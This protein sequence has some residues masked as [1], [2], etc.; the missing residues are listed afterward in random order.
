MRIS[1]LELVRFGHF[2]DLALRFGEPMESGDFHIVYGPN[3]SGKSTIVEAY[4]A[5]L[6]GIPERT[7]YAFRHERTSLEVRAELSAKGRKVRARRLARRKGDLYGD[8]EAPVPEAHVAALLG[9]V[10]REAYRQ[11]YCLDDGTIE[12]GG[13]EIL[14]SKGDLGRLLFSAAAGLDG[15]SDLLGAARELDEAFHQK[16]ARKPRRLNALKSEIEALGRAKAEADVTIAQHRD[17]RRRLKDADEALAEADAAHRDLLA[18]E[19]RLDALAEALPLLSEAVTARTALGALS[20]YPEVPCAWREEIRSLARR[21]AGAK[22]EL[23]AHAARIER[24]RRV[25]STVGGPCSGEG[26]DVEEALGVLGLPVSSGWAA[27]APGEAEAETLRLALET[28]ERAEAAAAAAEA[29]VRSAQGAVTQAEEARTRAESGFTAPDGLDTI[30]EEQSADRLAEDLA[31]ATAEETAAARV[32][33]QALD[34]LALPGREATDLPDA[35]LTEA[36]AR[37]LAEAIG[38]ARQE[39]SEARDRIAE[40]S[41][42]IAGLEAE[43]SSYRD[44]LGPDADGAVDEARAE[45]DR[46]WQDYRATPREELAVRV[47]AAFRETDRLA[48]AR[49]AE[50]ST[51]ASARQAAARL[52]RVS[53]ERADFAEAL[54]ETEARLAVLEKTAAHHRAA[55][56]LP[57]GATAEDLVAWVQERDH[58]RVALHDASEARRERTRLE[59][60]AE[61]VRNALAEKLGEDIRELSLGSAISAARS[62]LS[63]RK[64]QVGARQAATA[65]LAK[66][67]DELERRSG[68][69]QSLERDV[70]AAERAW[71]SQA[72]AFAAPRDPGVDRQALVSAVRLLS[73]TRA[74][75]DTRRESLD[76]EI[77]EAEGAQS[78]AEEA[79]AAVEFAADAMRG[80]F[81][82]DIDVSDLGALEGAIEASAR[83]RELRAAVA[84]LEQR[85][86]QRLGV[87]DWTAVERELAGVTLADVAVL[88]GELAPRLDAAAA[89]RDRAIGARSLAGAALAEAGS[90]ADAARLEEDRQTALAELKHETERA[91]VRRIGLRLADAAMARYRDRHRSAMLEDTGEAFAMLTEGRYPTIATQP[92]GRGERLLAE[93]ASDGR[94]VA[95]D[96]MSKGTRFQLYLALRFAGYRQMAASGTVLPFVCDDVFE[97]F[98][99]ARTAA[100]C[101][102]MR[103]ISGI[104]QAIYF[105]HHT[106]VVEIAQEVTH[107]AVAVHRID[108]PAAEMPRI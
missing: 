13:E 94:S 41:R 51:I 68:I 99:E 70:E 83:A 53:A 43:R 82:D 93:R 87:A 90:D 89:Q 6:Y 25:R 107:G 47:E 58:A 12:Q 20:R 106:H 3:E 34:R 100:A 31:R 32:M 91:L 65:A 24:L 19:A 26:G 63:E 108:A 27:M 88:R 45:R 11:L 69:Q 78:G 98:D 2:T 22:A 14:A 103:E 33:R 77:E 59:S 23:E 57:A 64:A 74:Q 80:A 15:L 35:P 28:L 21:R 29:E 67:K 96:A 92:A 37:E 86:V 81:P 55:T 1:R 76:R 40:R 46:L 52:A 62:A 97:T 7:P 49:L 17:L 8:G 44:A 16:R 60:R 4:L 5:L 18:Q 72:A 71:A 73:A 104:G 85:I 56:S 101:R 36:A 61:D 50:A 54:A 9:G 84:S 48:D 75:I 66:A 102:L 38:A 79:L 10:S 105:T 30:L 39:A 42:E 95:A